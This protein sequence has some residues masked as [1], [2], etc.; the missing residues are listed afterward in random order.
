MGT[1]SPIRIIPSA[2]L[3]PIHHHDAVDQ[4][5]LVVPEG[6]STSMNVTSR[7]Q[8]VGDFQRKT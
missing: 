3:H 2:F 8:I 7:E 5:F 4:N 1:S 6:A